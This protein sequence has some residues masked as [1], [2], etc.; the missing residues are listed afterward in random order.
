MNGNFAPEYPIQIK[1]EQNNN[2]FPTPVAHHLPL[3]F[4]QQKIISIIHKLVK[5]ISTGTLITAVH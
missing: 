1:S 3:F 5:A 2:D 4:T